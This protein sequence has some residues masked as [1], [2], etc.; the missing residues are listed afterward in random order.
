MSA[1]GFIANPRTFP[2]LSAD[3]VY[4]CT[5]PSPRISSVMRSV[6]FFI[7]PPI[8][9]AALISLPIAAVTTGLEPWI[10]LALSATP[11]EVTAYALTCGSPAAF[12]AAVA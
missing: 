7:I 5:G 4:P 12:G 2:A 9:N 10:C 6:S 11:P 8:I 3:T 1:R